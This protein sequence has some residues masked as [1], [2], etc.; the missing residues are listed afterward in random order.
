[1]TFTYIELEHGQSVQHVDLVGMANEIW[2]AALVRGPCQALRSREDRFSPIRPF[3]YI[4]RSLWCLNPDLGSLVLTNQ[5]VWVPA[6][7]QERTG[8][9]HFASWIVLHSPQVP[10]CIKTT[11]RLCWLIVLTTCYRGLWTNTVYLWLNTYLITPHLLT[12]QKL[13][14]AKFTYQTL[15]CEGAGTQTKISY[16]T[17]AQHHQHVSYTLH[18]CNFWLLVAVHNC[19]HYYPERMCKG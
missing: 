7:S 3:D 15:S 13:W 9:L 4:C 2:F 17:T 14:Y 10:W 16:T 12:I 5:L 19:S 6:P 18:T 8:L 11:C 1:M